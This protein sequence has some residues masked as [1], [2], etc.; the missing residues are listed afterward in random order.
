MGR[1]RIIRTA[2]EQRAYEERRRE[3]QRECQRRRRAANTTDEDRARNA[4]RLRQMRQ[5]DE[6]RG[7]ENASKRRRYHAAKLDSFNGACAKFKRD[8]LDRQYVC[9]CRVCGR[10][11]FEIDL[12]KIGDVR[13]P[14]ER[15]RALQ[16]L[17]DSLPDA[18][19]V[20]NFQVCGTCKDSLLKGVQNDS[21]VQESETI[22]PDDGPGW[23]GSTDES[24]MPAEAIKTE[25]PDYVE[26]DKKPGSHLSST[27]FESERY[28]ED[29]KPG[30]QVS[31]FTKDYTDMTEVTFHLN[32]E[33]QVSE[34]SQL[35][36]GTTVAVKIEPQDATEVCTEAVAMGTGLDG[37]SDNS[38]MAAVT[39][40][41]E[42]PEYVEQD[43]APGSHLVS[44]KSE[45]ECYEEVRKPRNHVPALT[46]GEPSDYADVTKVTFH[47]NPEL[48]VSEGFQQHGNAAVA[49]EIEPQDPTEV[50]NR[51]D[52]AETGMVRCASYTCELKL[53]VVEHAIEHGNCAAARH[54]GV[55]EQ[56]L[57]ERLESVQRRATRIIC[58]TADG[59]YDARLVW[60]PLVGDPPR[61]ATGLTD[62]RTVPD[63]RWTAFRDLVVL[64]SADKQKNWAA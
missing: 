14:A 53:K 3:Q 12:T 45:T 64:R 47:T 51:A 17:S 26:Q 19:D 13:D 63:A 8:F 30:S 58:G 24:V 15:T 28:G 23:G 18:G 49:A 56:H 7:A 52:P 60:V 41:T 34:A 62:A 46:E 20:E 38:A 25:P 61:E 9:S 21:E 31:T 57:W 6:R 59:S 22:L 29:W 40:K 44:V 39:I 10:L 35:Y 54:F 42:P 48:Q 32:A 33:P 55:D 4:K 11:W 37:S 43:E 16:V 27:E 5:D 50:N 36:D 2:E 1:P